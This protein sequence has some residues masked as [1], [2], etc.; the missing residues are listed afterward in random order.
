MKKKMAIAT[1][2]CIAVIQVLTPLSMIYKREATLNRG[3]QF[4]FD[5]APVDPYDAFRGRYVALRIAA[6][7][8]PLKVENGRELQG[9]KVHVSIKGREDGFAELTG[10]S[11]DAPA[12]DNYID[13]RVTRASG[14]KVYVN[15]PFDRYYM[16]E[17]EAP[18]AERAYWRS[19]GDT[20]RE[21]YV[22][23][24]VRSGFAVLEELYIQDLPISEFLK[25]ALDKEQ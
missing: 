1:F 19:S 15:L 9:R 23:V 25:K 16:D 20:D 7:R 10:V 22:T 13:C 5:T 14:S 4:K 6:E 18:A 21:A 8:E 2:A 3:R 17:Y 24:R 12:H 11:E